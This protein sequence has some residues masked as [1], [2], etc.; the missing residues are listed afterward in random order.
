MIISGNTLADEDT[1]RINGIKA[2]FVLNIAR[3]ITWPEEA[4]T[5]Q[6]DRLRLC[7]YSNNPLSLAVETIH[8][9]RAAGRLLEVHTIE[10]SEQEADCRILLLTHRE[11]TTF[12]AEYLPV[13]DRPT[14][15]IADLTAEGLET[16]ISRPGV[17]VSLVREGTRIALEVDL[18]QTRNAGLQMSSKLLR[19]ARIVGEDAAP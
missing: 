11:M 19:L 6:G 1:W 4:F 7:L 15:I 8:G 9:K 18:R 10:Q 2:A 16:G 17:L 14:L 13:P 12:H 3:F 5:G